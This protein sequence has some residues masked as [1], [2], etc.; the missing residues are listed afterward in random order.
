MLYDSAFPPGPVGTRHKIRQ[1]APP[2][3]FFFATF[4]NEI[5]GPSNMAN[6]NLI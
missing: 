6:W 1:T 2:A 5:T 4:V 3:S